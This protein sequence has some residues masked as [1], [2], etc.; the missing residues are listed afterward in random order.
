MRPLFFA[1]DTI[2]HPR[3]RE[4]LAIA[5]VAAVTL[6][7][8]PLVVRKVVGLGHGDTQVFF[9]AGWA[10]WTGYPLYQIT[11]HHG[12]TYH[13]P[14]TFALLMGPFANPLPGQPRPLW[15]LP[16]PAAVVVWYLINAACLIVALHVWG[17]ALECYRPIK[18]RPG[19]LH[20]AWGLRIG[21]LLAL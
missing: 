16:F 20:G 6:L 11:D 14:P 19:F 3:R 9:R 18:V 10:V 17:N 13:Y 2:A 1:L 7:F 4:W 21:P 8:L 5:A 15:A 12:W